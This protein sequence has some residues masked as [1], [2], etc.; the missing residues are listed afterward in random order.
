VHDHRVLGELF[1]PT[2][3]ASIA[4]AIRRIL[5]LAPDAHAA[6]VARCKAAA[7]ER[8]NWETEVARLVDLYRDLEA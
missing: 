4:A 3:P 7:R 8:W 6:L 5:E 1:D 2:S